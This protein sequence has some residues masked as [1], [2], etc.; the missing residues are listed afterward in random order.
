MTPDLLTQVWA[1]SQF[2]PD[3]TPFEWETILGQARQSRLLGRLAQHHVDQNWM[4]NVPLGPRRYLE[5]A[6]KMVDRQHHEVQWEVDCILRALKE[7]DA[8][9]V[10]LKGAA[11]FV[12]ELPARNGRLFSDIDIMVTRERLPDVERGATARWNRVKY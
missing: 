4:A 8:P 5:G 9:I 1:H 11:Y 3:L 10:M 12:A 7:L 2:R 6:L